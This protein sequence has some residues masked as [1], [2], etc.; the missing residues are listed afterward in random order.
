MSALVAVDP[1]PLLLSVLTASAAVSA[2]VGTRVHGESLPANPQM[3]ATVQNF[4]A[5][6]V[7]VASSGGLVDGYVLPL[8]YPRVQVRCYAPSRTQARALWF[9]VNGLL[10]GQHYQGHGAGLVLELNAG[11]NVLT[12]PGNGTPRVDGFYAAQVQPL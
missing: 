11:P 9:I 10:H 3:D 7:V 8:S 1:L 12:E 5:P 6:A 2:I 4:Y